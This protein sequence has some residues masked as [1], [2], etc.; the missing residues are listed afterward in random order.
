VAFPTLR[1]AHG[2][3][4]HALIDA[5]HV[6]VPAAADRQYTV[7]DAKV[8]A[9]GTCSAGTSVDISDGHT[10]VVVFTQAGL[11][12]A[13]MLEA[14]TA[15]TGV[16]TNLLTALAVNHPIQIK[17]VGDPLGTTTAIEYWVDYVVTSVQQ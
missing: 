12:N 4:D 3:A 5:G 8:R 10:T 1:T 15:T 2:T 6:I 11:V 9:T 7:T 17:T 14:G 16:G 13:T